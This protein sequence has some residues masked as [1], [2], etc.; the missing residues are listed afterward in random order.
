MNIEQS[1]MEGEMIYCGDYSMIILNG[2]LLYWDHKKET[3]TEIKYTSNNS[4][5]LYKIDIWSN[6]IIFKDK[7]NDAIDFISSTTRS[8]NSKLRC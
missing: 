4:A 8:G 7:S 5:Y 2:K 1:F 6:D 3:S